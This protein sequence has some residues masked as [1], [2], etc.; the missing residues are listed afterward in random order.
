MS[1]TMPPVNILFD[2]D[3]AIL[4]IEGLTEDQ[5]QHIYEIAGR[6]ADAVLSGDVDAEPIDEPVGIDTDNVVIPHGVFKGRKPADIIAEYGSNG[7][8]EMAKLLDEDVPGLV[9]LA[10]K[11]ELEK[12]VKELF[13]RND[14]EEFS[15]KLSE[16]QMDSFFERFDYAITPKMKRNIADAL[17]MEEYNDVIEFGQPEMKRLAVKMVIE[18]YH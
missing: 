14:P 8:Y 16:K 15:S 11:K 4:I 13:S 12:F 2:G 1:K 18:A 9:Y 3:K 7:A 6:V 10:I 5:K 17:R